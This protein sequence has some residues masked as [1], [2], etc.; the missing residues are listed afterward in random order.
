MHHD[1]SENQTCAPP[2]D[3]Q[4]A[5]PAC[6][7]PKSRVWSDGAGEPV[8]LCEACATAFYKRPIARTHDYGTYYPYLSAFDDREYRRQLDMRRSRFRFQ[9]REIERLD[10]PGRRLVDFGA[11]PGYFCAVARELGWDAA[12]IDTSPAAAR[13]GSGAFQIPYVSLD[14]VA[15]GSCSVVTAFHVIEHLED[16]TIVLSTL[17]RKLKT[18]GILVLHV[19]NRESLSSLFSFWRRKLV[20]RPATR[21][22]CLY[23]P[24]HLTGF[25]RTGLITCASRAQF[26]VIR[27]RNCSLFSRYYDSWVFPACLD[28]VKRDFSKG[29]SALILRSL[30]G[31]IDLVGCPIDRGDWLVAHFRAQ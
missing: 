18:G 10:P 23:Y 7:S 26:E 15:D 31:F 1:R 17:H 3:N 25:T 19:P 14:D 2:D 9:L 11:G 21:S 13:G 28:E 27:S 16:P 5:C 12:A 24:E 8:M 6:A 29:L 30:N 20:R 22:G 4:G